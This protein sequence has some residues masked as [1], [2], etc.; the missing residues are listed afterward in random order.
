M[1]SDLVFKRPHPTRANEPSPHLFVG[2][3]GPK[4]GYTDSNIRSIFQ[5]FVSDGGELL[6]HVPKGELSSHVYVSF[7]T[8]AEAAAAAQALSGKPCEAAGGRVLMVKFA[9]LEQP[10][11]VGLLC[12]LD[13]V[14][15]PGAAVAAAGAAV[16]A[17]VQQPI[18]NMHMLHAVSDRS[19]SAPSAI[20]LLLMLS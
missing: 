2:N 13:M 20:V 14:A 5:P 19:R 16:A 4:L 3:C 15:A 10:K 17:A 1:S 12:V 18:P 9:E 6:V 8:A 11:Q 7:S